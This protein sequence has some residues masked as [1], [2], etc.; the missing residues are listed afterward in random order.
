MPALTF[1]RGLLF[2]RIFVSSSFCTCKVRCFWNGVGV[3]AKEMGIRVSKFGRK[4][5]VLFRQFNEMLLCMQL[6]G[7]KLGMRLME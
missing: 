3:G 4:S 5:L 6:S 1:V 7:L 2:V